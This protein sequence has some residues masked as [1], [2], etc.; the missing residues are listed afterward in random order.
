MERYQHIVRFGLMGHTHD[1]YY[2]VTN[3]VSDPTKN[4]GLN[5]I[6]PSVTTNSNENPGFAIVDID[7]E[8]MLITNWEIWALDIE[9]ANASGEAVWE[10]VIDYVNDYGMENGMSPDGLYEVA[11]RIRD[12]ADYAAQYAWGESRFVGNK[13]THVNQHSTFCMLTS[14]VVPN[15]ACAPSAETIEPLFDQSLGKWN[16]NI[17]WLRSHWFNLVVGNWIQVDNSFNPQ[18]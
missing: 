11:E 2:S 14:G 17:N 5:Q 3:S 12:D 6:G 15:A 8:T 9:K 7:A 16:I 1:Q 10:K 18:E 4:I 13:P